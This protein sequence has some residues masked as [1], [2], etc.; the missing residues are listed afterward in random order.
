MLFCRKNVLHISLMP[1]FTR[2]NCCL[3]VNFR[4]V[5]RFRKPPSRDIYGRFDSFIAFCFMRLLLD[6]LY[7]P[8]ILRL[9]CTTKKTLH[10][11]FQIRII[12]LKFTLHKIHIYSLIH[13]FRLSN[14]L[15]YIEGSNPNFEPWRLLFISII[16][17]QF[18]FA[19]IA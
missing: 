13:K 7:F 6:P 12:L 15:F 4:S 1:A 5:C 8:D 17:H 3:Q 19:L 2:S 9:D 16:T 18:I 10:L 14:H 11:Y